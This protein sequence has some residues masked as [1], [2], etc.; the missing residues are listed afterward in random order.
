MGNVFTKA[1]GSLAIMLSRSR[2]LF[3]SAYFEKDDATSLGASFCMGQKRTPNSQAGNALADFPFDFSAGFI[4]GMVGR[5]WI[6]GIALGWN[7]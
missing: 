4:L 7:T 6:T 3:I 1:D 2:L 5:G